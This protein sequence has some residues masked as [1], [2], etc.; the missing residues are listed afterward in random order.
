MVFEE[1]LPGVVPAIADVG[2][3]EVA[4]MVV[5]GWKAALANGR[6]EGARLFAATAR[7]AEKL[8]DGLAKET[9]LAS[10]AAG[11]AWC[12]NDAHDWA[13]ADRRLSSCPVDALDGPSLA[14]LAQRVRDQSDH[15][16]SRARQRSVTDPQALAAVAMI[17]LEPGREEDALAL[18]AEAAAG[19]PSDPQLLAACARLVESAGGDVGPL[20]ER[21]GL[22]LLSASEAPLALDPLTRAADLAPQRSSTRLALAEALRLTG[23]VLDAV[24]HADAALDLR[25]ST[26][27][28]A[29]R[30]PA[31]RVAALV[32]AQTGDVERARSMLIEL[33]RIHQGVASAGPGPIDILLDAFLR[34]RSGDREGAIEALSTMAVDQIAYGPGVGELA[35]LLVESGHSDT[36]REVLDRAIASGLAD[37]WLSVRRAAL[38]DDDDAQVHLLRA[39]AAGLDP[40]STWLRYAE[41]LRR[42]DDDAGRP[43]RALSILHKVRPDDSEVLAKLAGVLVEAGRIEEAVKLIEPVA[44]DP[45]A[46]SRLLDW[47]A[48]A[49]WQWNEP[50]QVLP[51]AERALAHRP[52]DLVFLAIRGLSLAA[53]ERLSEA[54]T[55]LERVV[56]SG[57]TDPVV[58][59]NLARVYI[60]QGRRD[61]AASLVRSTTPDGNA[62]LSLIE[63]LAGIGVNELASELAERT[64][65]M[66]DLP[67]DLQRRLLLEL[68]WLRLRAD[69]ASGAANALTRA[70]E[71]DP[72]DA[73]VGLLLVIA[74]APD[75]SERARRL[76]AE[77]P[78][79]PDTRKLAPLRADAYLSVGDV[80]NA[81]QHLDSALLTWPRDSGLLARRAR[82]LLDEGD[83]EGAER[84]LSAVDR[85]ALP[86][87]AIDRLD[88][89][90]L[91]RRG[92]SK[93]ALERW[94][95]IVEHEP[96]DVSARIS[97]AWAAFDA[98][99]P[100]RALAVVQGV[101]IADPSTAALEVAGYALTALGRLEDARA[102]L[103]SALAAEPPSRAAHNMLVEVYWELGKPEQA[104]KHLDALGHV[105]DSW[106]TLE[107]IRLTSFVGRP[108]EAMKRARAYVNN[109]PDDPDGW[110]ILGSI[111]LGMEDT[112]GAIA[113]LTKAVELAPDN[114]DLL[115]ALGQA[116]L[117]GGHALD[118][119]AVLERA[120]DR[121][122]SS[123]G[124]T[125]EP[126]GAY[127]ALVMNLAEAYDALDDRDAAIARIEALWHSH[128]NDSP[129]LL[130]A[131]Q[132]LVQLDAPDQAWQ[133][134]RH[135]FSIEP[136]VEA[137]TLA[138]VLLSDAGFF[139]PARVAL[140]HA[141][142]RW[143]NDKRP[144][145]SVVWAL[146]HQGEE[147][148]TAYLDSVE[149]LLRDQGPDSWTCRRLGEAR[150][151]IGD[152]NGATQAFLQA[153]SLAGAS[154]VQAGL[155]HFLLGHFEEAVDRLIRVSV[156]SRPGS[157]LFD[158]ALALLAAGREEFA[159]T[160]FARAIAH[161]E[162]S[163][164]PHGRRGCLAVARWELDAASRWFVLPD[165]GVAAA[166]GLLD[167]AL[168]TEEVAN[169]WD[170]LAW[171]EAAI[172]KGNG[173][174]LSARLS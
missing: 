86:R 107:Y 152:R 93:G 75:D 15:L 160:E 95:R 62:I 169:L 23:R 59:A 13:D 149:R 2:V 165:E 87:S 104:L 4:G 79:D 65:A 113:S 157:E 25:R 145:P 129:L 73:E 99:D 40:K 5:G 94:S 28:D 155:S 60:K 71:I 56:S 9:L 64:L 167:A 88:A 68:G 46:D 1:P 143:P 122:E 3:A 148:A 19:A 84:D 43:I 138:G 162:R 102:A 48:E 21:V 109:S 156:P 7:H 29:R 83:L 44:D 42:F 106:S 140:E 100:A 22:L 41:D 135:L 58:V 119:V 12:T 55:A 141:R 72:H 125:D 120:L 33:A 170:T 35:R 172:P 153:L 111:Q 26:G 142:S 123:G 53:V 112:S 17:Q 97:L 124:S 20:L 105:S 85:D 108:S 91:A 126:A 38:S 168:A 98:D 51:V 18:L 133:L 163:W 70:R 77:I 115:G 166:H 89:E 45:H 171:V 150:L 114:V 30:G 139:R 146:R 127:P 134:A 57:F 80:L 49:L 103:E 6:E 52:D 101:P 36:A 136:T 78:A 27:L 159:L 158:L 63:Q 164:R 32:H 118:A 137:F 132:R 151:A 66:A 47:L 69:D 131:G 147:A 54:T 128:R 10:A 92:D 174:G 116:H 11:G 117:A 24:Q 161:N 34:E 130:D 14:V 50:D 110:N 37:P 96:D 144:L 173:A 61:Q 81:R 82:L 39:Q 154:L 31:L 16:L 90:L 8:P 121:A 74:F 67:P 76:L